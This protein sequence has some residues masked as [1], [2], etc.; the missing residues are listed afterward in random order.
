MKKRI[1]DQKKK[2]LEEKE[3]KKENKI[4]VIAVK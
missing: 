2:A 1:K 4:I 3:A